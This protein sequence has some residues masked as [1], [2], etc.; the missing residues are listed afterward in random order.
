MGLDRTIRILFTGLTT[1]IASLGPAIEEPRFEVIV[2]DGPLE[3][4]KY[5]P[6]I[7]A[8]VEVQGPWNQASNPAFRQ[9]ADFI[10][11]N[12]TTQQ[13]VAM[14]A[15]VGMEQPGQKI[16]MTAPVGMEP[17]SQKIA[18]T[19]PV[20]M[21]QSNPTTWRMSFT[22][23][24]EFTM[25]TLPKPNNSAVTIRQLPERMAAV[26]RF[27][28]AGREQRFQSHLEKLLQWLPTQGYEV[29][30]P[31]NFSQYNPPWTPGL[32]RRN[33]VIIPVKPNS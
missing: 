24:S 25:E 9:L 4:R 5:A 33:E 20:G 30:G 27:S 23:P 26:A 2:K 31:P 15:P 10:F 7:V 22:M 28:G 19:A 17:V 3:I 32:L 29:T 13:K 16:A 8:E 11:G 21:E 12:N 6:S 18:M 14:T 1:A